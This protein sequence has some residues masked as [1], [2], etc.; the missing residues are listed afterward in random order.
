MKHLP[1]LLCIIPLLLTTSTVLAEPMS[2]PDGHAGEPAP[3][4]CAADRGQQPSRGA[5]RGDIANLSI[6]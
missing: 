6:G 3:V 5:D 1:A 2:Y 4:E